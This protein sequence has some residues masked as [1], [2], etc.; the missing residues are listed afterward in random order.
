VYGE[1]DVVAAPEDEKLDIG[2]IGV[3]VVVDVVANPNE[4]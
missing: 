4:W 2:G 1:N 3:D